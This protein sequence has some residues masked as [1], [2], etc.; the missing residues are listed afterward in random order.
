[1]IFVN[2]F[3]IVIKLIFM[4]TKKYI[5]KLRERETSIF[6]KF[7]KTIKTIRKESNIEKDR[8]QKW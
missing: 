3:Q 6:F 5:L 1:M 2:L 7:E 8:C 4:L